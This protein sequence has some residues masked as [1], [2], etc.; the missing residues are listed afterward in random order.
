MYGKLPNRAKGCTIPI[1][2][3]KNCILV[4]YAIIFLKLLLCRTL[5]S[6]GPWWAAEQDRFF[7]NTGAMIVL[8]LWIMDAFGDDVRNIISGW[9]GLEV[10]RRFIFSVLRIS[11]ISA[12]PKLQRS[13]V[14]SNGLSTLLSTARRRWNGNCGVADGN[15]HA[16]MQRFSQISSRL[17]ELTPAELASQCSP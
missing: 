14:R 6:I 13:R 8:S 3:D 11:M 5:N 1:P 16:C 15:L 2:A 12:R 4:N 9:G 7:A 10:T 17:H